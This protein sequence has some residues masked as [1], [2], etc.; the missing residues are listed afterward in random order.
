M[1]KKSA[2]KARV[3]LVS[4]LRTPFA[5]QLSDY[6]KMTALDLGQMVVNELI[7]RSEIDPKL[8]D[9]LVYGQVIQYPKAPNIAREIVLLSGMSP[10]TDAYSV[11]RACATSFQS[12]A[13]VA[14]SIL[15]GQSAVG[16]AGGA[17]SSSVL[18]IQFSETLAASLLALSKAKSFKAK[19]Q[20]I[21]GI[22]PKHF[23][24]VPPAV[25]EYTTGLSMGQTAEQM[26]QKHQI[27]RAEQDSFAH[28]SHTLASLAWTQG[29]MDQ[30]V[31]TSLI[32]PYQNYMTKDNL[33]RE[34]SQLE[35]YAKLRPVFDK[36]HGT[37]TAANS[38][39]LTRWG[40][41][42]AHDERSK[43]QRAWFTTYRVFN[44]LC[45]YSH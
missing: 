26:A 2:A 25:Q 17:D 15:S 9:L 5:K 4:G 1:T 28:R 40:F 33:V 20:A 10:V 12:V 35:S 18:P 19:W 39:A 43:G 37:V 29:K 38:S 6:K 7:S 22:R 16:I 3:A 42:L 41:S 21:R 32:P 8:V 11:T 13:N 44:R 31:M 36:T 30:E 45:L 34:D 14:Q 27:S 24:P 23:A